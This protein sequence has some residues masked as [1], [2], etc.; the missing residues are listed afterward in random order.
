MRISTDVDPN[1][2][3]NFAFDYLLSFNTETGSPS[4]LDHNG[5]FQGLWVPLRTLSFFASLGLR[6]KERDE[7]GVQLDQN[8]SVNWAPFPD[9]LLNLSLAYN[10]SADT[11]ENESSIF[12]SQIDLQ[13]TRT[14]LLTLRYNVGTLE[15]DRETSDIQNVRVTLRTYY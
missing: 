12:S 14:T 8:Y 4:S 3:L 11:R 7:E 9:G 5:R 15:N 2:R 1:P 13:L 6:Y 10:H